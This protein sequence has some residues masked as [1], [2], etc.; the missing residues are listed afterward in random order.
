[1]MGSLLDG[2]RYFVATNLV[3][4]EASTIHVAASCHIN[5]YRHAVINRRALSHPHQQPPRGD[6]ESNISVDQP[7]PTAADSAQLLSEEGVQISPPAAF[8]LGHIHAQD[9]QH[10]LFPR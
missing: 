10:G 7:R 1:M 4:N 8:K 6:A 2:R 9:G 5:R 3:D